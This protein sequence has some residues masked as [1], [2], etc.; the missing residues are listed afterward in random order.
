VIG[1]HVARQQGL[2]GRNEIVGHSAADAAIGK[3]DDVL[4]RTI[5]VRAGF[6]NLAI[7]AFAA[8]FIDQHRE[9]SAV[10]IRHEMPDQ[11]GLAR[12]EEA[13]DDGDGNLG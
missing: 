4:F 11:R 2:H 13:G 12:A 8:E 7:D 10:C 6:Q 1:A 9:L 5:G 3:F